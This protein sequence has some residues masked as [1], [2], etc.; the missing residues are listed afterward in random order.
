M[1]PIEDHNKEAR[2]QLATSLYEL[3]NEL[4]AISRP[5][6]AWLVRQINPGPG[7][8]ILELLAGTG[9]TGF[10]AASF[11]GP[12]GKL[13]CSDRSIEALDVARMRAKELGINNV[14]FKVLN[15]EKI[16][17]PDNSV[18]AVICKWGITSTNYKETLRES[19]RVLR[20]GG[21]L[22]LAVWGDPIKNPWIS[23]VHNLLIGK[24]YIPKSSFPDI[25]NLSILERLKEALTESGFLTLEMSSMETKLR[26]TDKETYWQGITQLGSD[27]SGFMSTLREDVLL[28][29]RDLIYQIVE[30]YKLPDNSYEF[31]AQSIN[32]LAI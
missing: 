15:P 20:T 19:R 31:S 32:V 22:A 12:N 30:P 11:L 24:G 3:R 9:D 27:Y 18:D 5:V 28:E 25:F 13:I 1:Q 6:T 7:E 17:L 16:E 8:I 14:E 2:W 29:L 21:R 23:L 4:W 26:F 10:V